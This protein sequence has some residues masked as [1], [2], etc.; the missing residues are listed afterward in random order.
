MESRAAE[1]VI[2]DVR[3]TT[4]TLLLEFL[5]SDHIEVSFE[6]AMELFQA[7]DRFGIERLKKIC[8]GVLGDSVCVDTAAQIFLAADEFHALR[9][10]ERCMSFILTHF[11]EVSK[12]SCFEEMGR[13]NIDLIFEILQQR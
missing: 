4:F 12:T 1:V 6:N 9:L 13:T 2:D 8:E 10:R 5:Y 3:Y 7:A 11:D